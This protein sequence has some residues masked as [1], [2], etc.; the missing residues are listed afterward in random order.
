[1]FFV[2]SD[3][4]VLPYLFQTPHHK[5]ERF[6]YPMF[7]FPQALHGLPGGRIAAQVVSPKPFYGNNLA[8]HYQPRG[9]RNCIFARQRLP[10]VI[11]K[12]QAGTA[13]ATCI[14]LSVK[15]AVQGVFILV[16]ALGA[17][18]KD[19]HCCPCAVI[20]HILNDAEPRTAIGAIQERIAVPPVTPVQ[21]LREA[22]IASGNVGGYSH[23]LLPIV[24]TF[25]NEKIGTRVMGLY[26][27]GVCPLYRR[28]RWRIRL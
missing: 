9:C 3:H 2:D 1:M 22:L 12:Q 19:F 20:G 15:P 23:E 16:L 8:L 21:E 5:S 26:F 10:P 17:H 6:T 27:L 7:T 4:T 24:L 11:G 25:R 14:R 28:Q 13:L 18:G